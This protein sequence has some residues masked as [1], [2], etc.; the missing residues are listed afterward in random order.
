MQQ[1]LAHRSPLCPVVAR[2]NGNLRAE[3]ASGLH[4]TDKGM[5]AG[6]VINNCKDGDL[7]SALKE[8]TRQHFDYAFESAETRGSSYMENSQLPEPVIRAT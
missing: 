2:P 3:Y 4:S 5:H 7:V 6:T 8:P 1:H